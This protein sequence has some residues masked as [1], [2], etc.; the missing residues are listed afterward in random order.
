MY[1]AGSVTTGFELDADLRVRVEEGLRVWTAD[2]SG[3]R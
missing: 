3:L 1:L 2:R